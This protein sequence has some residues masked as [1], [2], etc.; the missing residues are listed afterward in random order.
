[1][2]QLREK[3]RVALVVYA[4]NAGLVLP[5]TSGGEKM[6]IKDAIDRLAAGGSTA[7]GAGIQLAY[8][9]ARENFIKSGNNRIIL[10]SDGDFNVGASSD[11]ALEAMIETE[12]KSGVYLTILGYGTGNYQDAKMQKLAGK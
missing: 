5:S 2:D 4:G 10:C 1:V 8:K 12:R 7:G 3:D 11:A 6:K 9:T